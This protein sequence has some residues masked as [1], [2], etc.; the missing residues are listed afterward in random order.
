MMEAFTAYIKTIRR[1]DR[2]FGGGGTA[3]AK[4]ELSAVYQMDIGTLGA[5]GGAEA[6]AGAVSSGRNG[7]FPIFCIAGA[8]G[9]L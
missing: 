2:F 1:L 4:R 8:R 3:D 5:F 7:F 6:Y 9:V